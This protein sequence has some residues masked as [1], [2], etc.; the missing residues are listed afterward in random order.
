MDPT[1]AED[2]QRQRTS[3]T[4][5]NE[6]LRTEIELY[7]NPRAAIAQRR[8]ELDTSK[9]L[10]DDEINDYEIAS[11]CLTCSIAAAKEELAE[12]S[13]SILQSISLAF[14]G[15]SQR[16]D[17]RRLLAAND[18]FATVSEL[19]DSIETSRDRFDRIE[20]YSDEKLAELDHYLQF[21]TTASELDPPLESVFLQM[22]DLESQIQFL[23][24]PLP[25]PETIDGKDPLTRAEETEQRLTD[26]L[27]LRQE[28]IDNLEAESVA[29]GDR[30]KTG[31]SELDRLETSV[32]WAATER[33][34]ETRKIDRVQAETARIKSEF[35][36]FSEKRAQDLKEIEDALEILKNTE[37][38]RDA[39]VEE[40]KAIIDELEGQL[41]AIVAG[42]VEKSLPAL[43][44]QLGAEL[45]ER[46]EAV[47]V[48]EEGKKKMER[49]RT[50]L[51]RKL[52]VFDELSLRFSSRS[53]IAMARGLG[54]LEFIYD[55]V[56]THNKDMGRD[57][58]ALTQ[59]LRALEEE[60]R[61]LKPRDP[62]DG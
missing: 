62:G 25:A 13:P 47:K 11:D 55:T 30:L 10:L 44:A 20:A 33:R 40:H 45:A 48:Y 23:S 61:K 5:E 26:T 3:L 54:E 28:E 1:S 43:N 41:D 56:V 16:Q 49:L 18:K 38:P 57:M 9:A 4:T 14:P 31:V 34:D 19:F 12:L 15:S 46:H 22:V 39:T 50:I 42:L 52:D 59:E 21:C 8:R 51:N 2:F 58:Q 17:T 35:E 27:A 24:Q 37:K 7:N 6:A 36:A 60:N 53:K 29:I 32:R